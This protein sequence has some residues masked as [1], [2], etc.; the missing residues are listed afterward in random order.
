MAKDKLNEDLEGFAELLEQLKDGI[1]C[2]VTVNTSTDEET[3]YQKQYKELDSSVKNFLT[4][5]DYCN[6][7]VLLE[8]RFIRIP[9]GGI[10]Y[11]IKVDDIWK[12]A[13]QCMTKEALDDLRRD[14]DVQSE[15]SSDDRHFFHIR[16][17]HKERPELIE[18]LR[19]WLSQGP[20]YD[21][22]KKALSGIDAPWLEQMKHEAFCN[23]RDVVQEAY[24]N[25]HVIK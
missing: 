1:E 14:Y 23:G 11:A 6:F 2:D 15:W 8:S 9:T 19:Y 13:E 20:T 17:V 22:M 25:L 3:L 16:I 10:I 21:E 4:R 7:K 18:K 12:I 24:R 5:R